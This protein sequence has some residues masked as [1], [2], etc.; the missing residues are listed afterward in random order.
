MIQ[1]EDL[2]LLSAYADGELVGEDLIRF[3]ERL[4]K[5]PAL[6]R[7]L[8]AIRAVDELMISHAR[9]IDDKPVPEEIRALVRVKSGR[10]ATKLFAM[11]AAVFLLTIGSFILA[12][13]STIDYAVVDELESGQRFVQGDDYIEVIASFRRLD[14]G[15]CREL[16]T[17][18]AH[19]IVCRQNTSWRIEVEVPRQDVPLNSYQPAGAGDIGTIDAFVREHMAGSTIETDEER[20]LIKQNW[21]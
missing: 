16:V 2:T 12:P 8:D 1:D 9:Q 15:F 6:R 18:T 21:R 20:K 14:G 7:E 11:A 17:S 5:E 13:Q 3:S 19:R 10:S 4:L